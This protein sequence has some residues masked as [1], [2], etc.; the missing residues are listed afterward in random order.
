MPTQMGTLAFYTV[1][2][3]AEKFKISPAT[4]YGYI[5]SGTLPAKRFGKHFQIEQGHIE[6]FL[7]GSGHEES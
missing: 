3:L 5:R 4:I 6:Q 2:E 7:V 1:E